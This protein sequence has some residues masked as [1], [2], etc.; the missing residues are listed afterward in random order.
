MKGSR[1]KNVFGNP[2]N[3][4]YLHLNSS[5]I[6]RKGHISLLLAMYSEI[7]QRPWRYYDEIQLLW[8]SCFKLS[9]M[10]KTQAVSLPGAVSRISVYAK[11]IYNITTKDKLE[12]LWVNDK[13]SRYTNLNPESVQTSYCL[14]S[15]KEQKECNYSSYAED[16]Y[17]IGKYYYLFERRSTKMTG[18]VMG[19]LYSKM[20]SWKDAETICRNIGG[21][22][23]YFL[24]REELEE[25]TDF[26]KNSP[27]ILPYEAIYIG[28]T[29][30]STQKVKL[31]IDHSN[32][33]IQ[34]SILIKTTQTL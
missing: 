4:F 20:W 31:I 3:I 2:N 16:G 22:L 9:N 8:T 17:F 7:E 18:S 12:A 25:L 33:V 1:V 34:C 13:Q 32:V 28:M 11:E 21:H 27:H 26:L 30:N 29:L 24:S 19:R 15:F 5:K 23:P 6:S 10:F 14:E